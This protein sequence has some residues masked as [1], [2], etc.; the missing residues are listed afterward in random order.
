MTIK[1]NEN[2]IAVIGQV[3]IHVDSQIYTIKCI[4]LYNK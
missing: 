2:E 3:K 4:F 1:F